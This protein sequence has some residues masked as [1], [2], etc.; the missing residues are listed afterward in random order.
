MMMSAA[1]RVCSSS[2]ATTSAMDC[3]L[4]L[5]AQGIGL[6]AAHAAQSQCQGWAPAWQCGVL[7]SD[8]AARYAAVQALAQ[9]QAQLVARRD[10]LE[11]A[12]TAAAQ[13]NTN[14]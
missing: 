10:E 12:V 4:V 6:P 14:V 2:G 13:V 8:D 11:G 1:G 7:F 3:S 5:E 9:Q